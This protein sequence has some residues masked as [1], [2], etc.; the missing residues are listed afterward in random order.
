[1]CAGHCA[2]SINDVTSIK[3]LKNK[4]SGENSTIMATHRKFSNRVECYSTNRC[5]S[6]YPTKIQCKIQGTSE[7]NSSLSLYPK[8][9]D[10]SVG[11]YYRRER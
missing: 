8:I 11:G 2:S 1:M 7:E 4:T 6:G 3:W 5:R 10:Y 9:F